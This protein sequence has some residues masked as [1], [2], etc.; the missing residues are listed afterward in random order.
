MIFPL[1]ELPSDRTREDKDVCFFLNTLSMT[2]T[3]RMVN[4]HGK[5]FSVENIFYLILEQIF[6]KVRKYFFGRH[7]VQYIFLPP[8]LPHLI[9]Q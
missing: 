3:T 7:S 8:H 9:Q 4:T 5:Q 2:L 6:K 1:F